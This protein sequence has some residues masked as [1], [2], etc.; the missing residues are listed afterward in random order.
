MCYSRKQHT[1]IAHRQRQIVTPGNNPYKD[2]WV[3]N[4]GEDKLLPFKVTQVGMGLRPQIV[5]HYVGK[6]KLLPKEK[7]EGALSNKLPIRL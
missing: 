5:V 4:Y 6:L 7:E 1:Y 3:I 2:Y